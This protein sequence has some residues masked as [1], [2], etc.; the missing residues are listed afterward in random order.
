[1]HQKMNE[2]FLL[3]KQLLVRIKPSDLDSVLNKTE[4]CECKD[5]DAIFLTK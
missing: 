3:R 2:I 1:M 4:N 5:V